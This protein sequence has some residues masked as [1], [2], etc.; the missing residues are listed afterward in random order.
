MWDSA[1]GS[2]GWDHVP[3]RYF[4]AHPLQG[5]LTLPLSALLRGGVTMNGPTASVQE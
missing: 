1:A 5:L 2:P 4:Q 3:A